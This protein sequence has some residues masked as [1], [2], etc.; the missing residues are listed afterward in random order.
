MCARRD[1][2]RTMK[3]PWQA[4]RPLGEVVRSAAPF[5][6]VASG[7]SPLAKGGKI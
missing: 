4:R 5:R 6:A 2:H 7:G 3:N 1:M